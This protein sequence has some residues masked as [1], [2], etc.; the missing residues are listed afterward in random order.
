MKNLLIVLLV[1]TTSL[2]SAQK[3]DFTFNQVFRNQ[4]TDFIKP[5]PIVDGWADDSHYIV[6][7]KSID[8]KTGKAADYTTATK[9][10]IEIADARNITFSPNSKW[11]AYTKKDNNLYVKEITTGKETPLTSDGS[12]TIYN[13]YASW[14]YYEEILG[15]PSHYKAFWWSPDSKSIAYMHF[16][17]AEVPVFPIYRSEGQHGSLEN[18][19]YPKVGDKNPEVKMGI[20]TINNSKTVWADFNEKD[21]QYFGMPVWTTEGKLWVQWMPRSQDNL[22]IYE[23]NSSTGAK[24]EIYNEDQKTWISLDEDDRVHFIPGTKN[25]LLKSD[26]TG[27]RHIYLYDLSGKLI[28]PVTQGEFTVLDIVHA[29]AKAKLIYFTARK[30]N[31]ARIDFY[32]TGFDGKGLTRLTFGEYTHNIDASP[33]MKY[34]ITTYSNLQSPPKMAIVDNKGKIVREIGDARGAAFANYNLPKAELVRIKSTDGLF[35]LPMSIIYPTHFDATKKYPVLINIY[36]GPDATSVYDSWRTTALRAWWAQ[37]GIIQVSIDNRSSGH[38]GKQGM[39]YIYRQ[40]GKYE[41]EDFVAGARW[42]RNQSFVDGNKI[43]IS[44]GSFG[45]YMSCM[46]LTYAAGEFN[47]A[48]ADAPVTD[49][50]LYDTHYTERFMDT[51]KENPDGYKNT[52][53]ITYADKYKGLLRIIHGTTDDNVHMQNTLQFIDKLEDLGKHF[54]FMLYPGE[55]HGIGYVNPAKG[56]HI[57]MENYRFYYQYLLNKEMPAAFGQ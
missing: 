15:R 22:K 37:E 17:D 43:C 2:A 53:V 5:L 51:P 27:W 1:F 26:K 57:K 21:D 44:G 34:F 50:K 49:W 13:G 56:T 46:A 19:R 48:I 40:L 24:K 35:D 23:I 42:L 16:N 4:P 32:K 54:E 41:I 38:F 10:T 47:Y 14:V 39:N 55:R 8:I 30:E 12:E 28:N 7:G 33:N 3:K 29:D 9:T 20:V 25:V 31:S 36:G 6:D 45:G 18:T 11:V 52:S